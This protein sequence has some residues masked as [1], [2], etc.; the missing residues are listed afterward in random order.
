[1]LRITT[2]AA[3]LVAAAL[4]AGCGDDEEDAGSGGATTATTQET[5]QDTTGTTE[6]TT[7]TTPSGGGPV[8]EIDAVRKLLDQAVAK[9]EAGDAKAAERL[10]GDAYLEH[11]EEVEHPLEERDAELMERLE[12]AISTTIRERIK[13]GA[14][15]G[16]V[17][18]LV[19]ETKR[20]LDGAKKLLR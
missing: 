6:E 19:E 11:F 13:A 1:M 18:A 20:Q 9:Y 2:L 17:A 14:P 16:E 10:V 7:A 12:K 15:I 4:I 3:T 5:T 8:A